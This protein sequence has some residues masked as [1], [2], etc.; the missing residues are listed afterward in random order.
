MRPRRILLGEARG[1]EMVAI[2]EAMNTGHDGCMF[3]VHADDAFKTLQR[4]E[5]LYLKAGMG[6]VPLLAVRREIAAAVQIV[7]NI[8]IF[9]VPGQG[10]IRRVK[11]ISYVTGVVEGEIMQQEKIF[12]WDVPRGQPAYMGKLAMTQARPTSLIAR[13]EGVITGFDWE[14]DVVGAHYD[15]FDPPSPDVSRFLDGRR[16]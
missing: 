1:A 7:V 14:R 12:K 11:E 2:L 15:S 9:Y 4:I 8:G 16:Q 10:E 5:T 6:N 3:T 13:L